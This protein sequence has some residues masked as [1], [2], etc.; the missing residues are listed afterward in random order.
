MLTID[1]RFWCSDVRNSALGNTVFLHISHPHFTLKYTILK[2]NI[3]KLSHLIGS[4][5]SPE[6]K[7][8]QH[9]DFVLWIFP[10]K[11]IT[12]FVRYTVAYT[13]ENT[14]EYTYVYKCVGFHEVLPDRLSFYLIA[15][16]LVLQITS[17]CSLAFA[18]I[19]VNEL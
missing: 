10:K 3:F 5:P 14:Y 7:F 1:R 4:T 15:S 12:L 17:G 16:D 19:T 13:Y 11:W 9:R 18:D 2:S 6:N 8:I